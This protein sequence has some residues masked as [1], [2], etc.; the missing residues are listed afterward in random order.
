MKLAADKMEQTDN[1][2]N[3]SRL[4]GFFP[5]IDKKKEESQ[6]SKAS[7]DGVKSASEQ[8]AGVMTQVPNVHILVGILKESLKQQH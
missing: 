4:S 7:R 8:I 1:A 5:G 6:L 3:S 2:L